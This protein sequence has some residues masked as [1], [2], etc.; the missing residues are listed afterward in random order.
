VL[1]GKMAVCDDEW[2]TA[3]SF[4][5]NDLSAHASVELNV[6]VKN[7][8]FAKLVAGRLTEIIKTD[9]VCITPSVYKQNTNV[10]NR[11]VQR[12]AY[13]FFRLVLFLFTFYFRQRE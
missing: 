10:F 7:A 4:N 1:H 6:D 5:V 9:C 13:D 11:V 3:G 2:I 12:L 8:H